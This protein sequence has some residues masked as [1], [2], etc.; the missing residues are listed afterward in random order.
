[1]KYNH[2]IHGIELKRDCYAEQFAE[3]GD[4]KFNYMVSCFGTTIMEDESPQTVAKWLFMAARRLE[5]MA[6]FLE[7]IGVQKGRFNE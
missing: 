6:H 2:P 3:A 4:I 5:K 7:K 1:M